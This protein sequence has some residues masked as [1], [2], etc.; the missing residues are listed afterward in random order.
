LSQKTSGN[1]LKQKQDIHMSEQI[2]ETINQGAKSNMNTTK[3]NFIIA[4]AAL[5]ALAGNNSSNAGVAAP[6]GIASIVVGPSRTEF[7]GVPF[8]RPIEFTGT[9]NA[10][11][12]TAGNDTY[13][14]ALDAGQASLPTFANGSNS[15]DAWYVLE[16]LDGPSIG[17]LLPLTSNT[18]NTEVIVQGSAAGVGV[19][20]GTRFGIRKDWTL[21][22]LFGAAST[23]NRFGYGANSGSTTVNAWVQVY[24]SAAGASTTYFIAESGTTTKS[25]NWRSTAS[26]TARN[27]VRVSLGRG[28]VV[29]NRKAVDLTIPIAGEYRESRTRL[30]VPAGK[31][32][33]VSNPGASAVTFTDATIPAT[34]P[35][36]ATSTPN[37]STGDEWAS[38]DSANRAWAVYRTGGTSHTN[39]PSMYSSSTRVNPTIPAYRAVR[40]KPV[41]ATGNV[42]VTIAPSL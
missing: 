25:Y 14:V 19:P 16:I 17:F 12:T 8:A 13:T 29:L 36:R 33:Y 5:A 3:R 26:T 22:S 38:W 23:S 42:V 20:V 6:N 9:I 35:T 11:S 27:H 41:G 18:G 24:D 37:G 21:S 32:T 1:Y 34:S 2:S 30:S 31:I 4:I 7:V 10:V 39:G 28:A 40:V 15:T